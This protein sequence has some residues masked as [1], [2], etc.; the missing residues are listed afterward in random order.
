MTKGSVL[1]VEP[2]FIIAKSIEQWLYNKGYTVPAIVTTG[3]D[4]I[5]E[6]ANKLPDLIIIDT[7]LKGGESGIDVALAIKSSLNIPSIQLAAYP[8]DLSRE[9]RNRGE[10]FGYLIKPFSEKNLQLAVEMALSR[11]RMERLVQESGEWLAAIVRS[12]SDAVITT[13]MEGRITSMNPSAERTTGWTLAEAKNT[14]LDTIME[15]VKG[16]TTVRISQVLASCTA[17]PAGARDIPSDMILVPRNG[18]EIPIE[19][20]LA[21]MQH[22]SGG[23]FGGV[24]VYRDITER[25]RSE[26]AVRHYEDYLEDLVRERT[27]DLVHANGQ[28]K[29]EILERSLAETALASER[30]RL[31]ATLLAIEDGVIAVD[32]SERILFMNRVATE[33][34]GWDVIEAQSRDI[35]EVFCIRDNLPAAH[36][37]ESG[38]GIPVPRIMISGDGTLVSRTGTKFTVSKTVS[39]IRTREGQVVGSVVT[40]R[41]ITAKLRAEQEYIRSQN[42]ASIGVLAGGVAH[43]LNNI[44]TAIVGNLQLC[45]IAGKRDEIETYLDEAEHCLFRVRDVARQLLTFSHGGTPVKRI[46]SIRAL[47]MGTVSGMVTNSRIQFEFSIPDDLLSVNV[48]ESQISQAIHNVILNAQQAMK[49]GGVIRVAARNE[50]AR[51]DWQPYV[52]SRACVRIS[53]SD[54]GSG[55]GKEHMQR[56]FD[57]YFSTKP[58]SAGIG[59]TAVYSILRRHGGFVDVDS[60]PGR[61]SVF[62]LV[63]PSFGSAK[64]PAQEA[65]LHAS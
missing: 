38:H 5:R 50:T 42:L 57:P 4:A 27:D 6:A 34:T 29:H 26:E 37:D 14:P 7:R 63:I 40:F 19:G 36:D 55:I 65:E 47:I 62:H 48:D 11:H 3:D 16:R 28:L 46:T 23:C 25:R 21:P 43:D 15:A 56:I 49:D 32:S 17:G 53:V 35:A 44:L 41:D 18:S 2:E 9:D 31:T 60:E 61:G 10:I 59:L 51:N 1:I 45:R 54:Q 24:M 8:E 58:G 52:A 13:D 12:I 64:E 20:C 30:D 22:A 33:L 39:S